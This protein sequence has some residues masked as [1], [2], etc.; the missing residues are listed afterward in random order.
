MTVTC[1][2]FVYVASLDSSDCVALPVAVGQNKDMNPNLIPNEAS[3]H[4]YSTNKGFQI[5]LRYHDSLCPEPT[6]WPHNVT[7]CIRR[8]IFY[9]LSFH[10]TF[11]P[12]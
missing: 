3:R 10:L 8:A 12:P 1:I 5:R 6:K 9:L 7:C 2:A 11:R 4:E